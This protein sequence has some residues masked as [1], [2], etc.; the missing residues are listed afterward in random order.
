M[1]TLSQFVPLGV[2]LLA[3]SALSYQLWALWVYESPDRAF[4]RE[5]SP[6]GALAERRTGTPA[7]RRNG[8]GSEEP[9][10]S[11]TKTTE[12]AVDEVLARSPFLIRTTAFHVFGVVYTLWALGFQILVEP[13]PGSYL[14]TIY[15]FIVFDVML[16]LYSNAIL[17]LCGS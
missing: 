5:A 11:A 3:W 6:A 9:T 15:I 4:G 13:L 10:S 12:A 17:V 16:F 8:A 7:S 2:A 14:A 1:I